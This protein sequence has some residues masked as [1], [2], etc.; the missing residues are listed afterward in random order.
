MKMNEAIC[1]LPEEK[2]RQVS[3]G[4]GGV[5]YGKNLKPDSEQTFVE[6]TFVEA[7]PGT[8]GGAIYFG[9]AEPQQS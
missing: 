8:S 6:I 4:D 5:I 3:G 7:P 1:I 9:S 2:L